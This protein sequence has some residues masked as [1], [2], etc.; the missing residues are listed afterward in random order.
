MTKLQNIVYG[1]FVWLVAVAAVVFTIGV[2]VN[3]W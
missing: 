2:M 3:A 1:G